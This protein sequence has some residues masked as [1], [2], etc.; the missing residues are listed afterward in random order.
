MKDSFPAL[1]KLQLIKIINI[2]TI[3]VGITSYI[4]PLTYKFR[5]EDKSKWIN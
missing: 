5:N 1:E 2:K 3:Y 4:P